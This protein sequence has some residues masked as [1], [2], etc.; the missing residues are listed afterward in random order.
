MNETQTG[1]SFGGRSPLVVSYGV[2]RD[3]T[4]VLVGL[5]QRGL[6]PD[7]V[8]FADVGA[9]RQA[10][11]DYIPVI[12]AWLAAVGFPQVTVVRYVPKDYKHWPPYYTIEENILTNVA[13]PSIAY[14]GHNCSVKWKID[15]QNK[16]LKFWPPAM[17]AWSNGLKVR[18]MIG[19]E[20]SP[21][22]HR[23]RERG[24]ATFAVQEDEVDKFDL[25]Y[26]LQEWG[27]N[28]DR[29]LAEIANEGLPAPAKSSCYFCT[30]MKPWEVEELA[31]IDPDK[32]RR[33][34]IVEA[35]TV[36][37]HLAYAEEKGWPRGV[38]KPLTEGIW[39]KAVK[40]MRGA[41]PRP[42]SM[43]EYIRQKNLLPHAEIDALIA[44]TPTGHVTKQ[45][46][47]H[48]GIQNW[49]HWLELICA[50]ARDA[51]KQVA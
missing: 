2:G 9:E 49:Q 31:T 41:T 10:T 42:G 51:A 24:C 21:H 30:A 19:F 33:L 35:R 16:F 22:E 12:N 36:K 20:D 4:A 14:G 18:K 34:V 27:W 44:L 46:F 43:T 45:D 26:P 29:C 47:D 13:L 28:L 1:F 3:S 39:R 48:Q 23:R 25:E 17:E 7:L 6:R 15:P 37:R 50:Q 40:G 38:G 5:R 8:L 32:L 11:Y